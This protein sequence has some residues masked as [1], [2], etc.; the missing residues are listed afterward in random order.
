[1]NEVVW[2]QWFVN[3]FDKNSTLLAYKSAFGGVI[4]N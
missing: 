4:K 2:F 3:F 1:M